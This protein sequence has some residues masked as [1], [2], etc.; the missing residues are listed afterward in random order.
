M[1]K[2]IASKSEYGNGWYYT[3]PCIICD[4]PV[5]LTNEE[6]KMMQAGHRLRSRVCD[7]CKQVVLHM[8]DRMNIS[9]VSDDNKEECNDKSD[10]FVITQHSFDPMENRLD[11]ARQTKIVGYAESEE[12]AYQWISSHKSKTYMGWDNIEYPY[13]TVQNIHKVD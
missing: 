13:Y 6:Y 2:V 11:S 9:K 10:I 12:S 3:M 7:K 4:E 8:R 1:E 5:R